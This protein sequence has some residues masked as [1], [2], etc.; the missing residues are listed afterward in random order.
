MG[1]LAVNRLHERLRQDMPETVRIL[2]QPSIIVRESVLD[3]NS[4]AP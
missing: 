1:A 4:M 3:L 2:V